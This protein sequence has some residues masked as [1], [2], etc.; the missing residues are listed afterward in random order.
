M[1][2]DIIVY[3]YYIYTTYSSAGTRVSAL[4]E[5]QSFLHVLEGL[6]GFSALKTPMETPQGTLEGPGVPELIGAEMGVV[7][8]HLPQ[9]LGNR[10]PEALLQFLRLSGNQECLLGLD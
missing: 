4:F 2:L 1:S 6:I 5:K 8:G 10:T 7:S 9:T 3:I